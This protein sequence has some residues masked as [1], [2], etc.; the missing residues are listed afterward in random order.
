MADIYM[1]SRMAKDVIKNIEYAFNKKI[2]SNAAQGPDPLYYNFFS[3]EHPEYRKY[4][5]AMHRKD[6]DLL[7]KIMT[8]YVK[9]NLTVD[10]YSFL[11]GFICHYA[12]D[13]KIHPYVY[14]HVGVYKK[15]DKR[16][17][18]WR[19]LHLKFERSIDAVLI[20]EDTGI[21]PRKMNLN[22][23]YFP[24]RSPSLEIMKI[25]DHILKE[26]YDKDN[27]GVMYLISTVEMRK[28][29]K[30]FVKDKRGIKKLIFKFIDL[31][32]KK[33][34][35]FFQDMSMFNHIEKYDFLNKEKHTWYHPVTNEE[36]NYS[37][38][39]LYDQAVKFASELIK[40][41]RLYI[42]EDEDIDLSKV[43]TNLSFNTGINCDHE[44]EMKYFNIYRK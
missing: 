24:L 14:N 25:W 22:T 41:I 19:G 36:Y 7:L 30:R 21:K 15:D 26:V 27:G 37:V 1:H 12:L 23:K 32:N 44:G 28:N 16:T 20:E 10:S 31:I 8:N 17:H 2:V 35:M 43:F 4:A 33:H 42:Y 40:N 13:V 6:T 5:D 11:V 9:E 38:M 29:I 39:E 18:E 34:D 3:K